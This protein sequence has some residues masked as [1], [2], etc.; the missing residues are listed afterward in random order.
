MSFID[1]VS[2]EDAAGLTADLYAEARRA[3]GRVLNLHRAFA[4]LPS[5]AHH[6]E[7]MTSELKS[8]MGARRYELVT[9]AAALALR[10][11]YCALAHASVLMRDG[12]EEDEIARIAADRANAQLTDAEREMM[13]YAEEIVRDAA[14]IDGARVDSLRRLGLSDA[15]ISEVAAAASLRCYFSKYLDA[16]GIEPDE[17][18]S[19]LSPRLREVLVRGRKIADTLPM[20]ATS[21]A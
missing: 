17:G 3:H 2:D 11:S 12:V 18:Y 8:R 20:D 10:S 9:I 6:F 1:R 14:A 13:A 16:V 5:F 7:A 19:A 15:E 21:Q 4:H